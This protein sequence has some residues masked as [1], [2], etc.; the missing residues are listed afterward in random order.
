MR[1]AIQT[2]AAK[3]SSS[4]HG[5][6]SD[7]IVLAKKQ[8]SIGGK[9]LQVHFFWS[10]KLRNH[11]YITSSYYTPP[12]PLLHPSYSHIF[13]S[14]YK[15]VVKLYIR[16]CVL[17]HPFCNNLIQQVSHHVNYDE[18]HLSEQTKKDRLSEILYCKWIQVQNQIW[19]WLL[20]VPFS[21]SYMT[22][23]NLISIS[24]FH[25]VCSSFSPIFLPSSAG[26]VLDIK[27]FTGDQEP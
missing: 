21:Q 25:P 27:T 10:L 3:Y 26:P 6:T 7:Q 17:F 24:R 12:P 23:R 8:E 14:T 15:T 4:V 1:P 5:G 18:S 22:S 9:L 20:Q 16:V 19:K 2:W 11:P 13:T